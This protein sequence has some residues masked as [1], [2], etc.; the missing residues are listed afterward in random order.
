MFCF[1]AFFVFE[2]G[3]SNFKTYTRRIGLL[4]ALGILGDL[5]KVLNDFLSV[6]RLAGTALTTIDQLWVI[7]VFTHLA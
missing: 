7:G 6:L 4:D 5:S 2:I 3:F 1:V